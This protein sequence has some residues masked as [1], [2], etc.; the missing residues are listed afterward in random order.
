MS[1]Y[2]VVIVLGLIG[3]FWMGLFYIN[4]CT[5][6]AEIQTLGRNSPKSNLGGESYPGRL[7]RLKL[8][9]SQ[10]L[11]PVIDINLPNVSYDAENVST[12]QR[13]KE[14]FDS[15]VK[16]QTERRLWLH[17]YSKEHLGRKLLEDPDL[18]VVI[19]WIADGRPS[20]DVIALETSCTRYLWLLWDQLT[21]I[22]SV[23]YKKWT[24][25]DGKEACNIHLITPYDIFRCC[26]KEKMSSHFGMKKTEKY[27]TSMISHR[28]ENHLSSCNLY[29]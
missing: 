20:R 29:N 10:D 23:L 2:I 8:T 25:V 5:S 11:I 9:P 1:Y 4:N 15:K 27:S 16:T 28:E 19:I 7:N 17:E 6:I 26:Q 13:D 3:V 22:N 12:T 21:F 14:R 18:C 24:S